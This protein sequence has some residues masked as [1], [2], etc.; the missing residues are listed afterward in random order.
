MPPLL[1]PLHQGGSRGAGHFCT[2]Q[3]WMLLP[4]LQNGGAS[5]LCVLWLPVS[6]E[7]G[8]SSLVRSQ[9][10]SPCSELAFQLWPG[11]ILR[12]KHPEGYILPWGQPRREL[13]NQAPSHAPG[14][15]SPPVLWDGVMSRLRTL[16]LHAFVAPV[17][18]VLPSL[19][20]GPQHSCSAPTLVFCWRPGEH[21][22]PS[23]HSQQ[24]I[25]GN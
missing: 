12:A 1:P 16:Q 5:R 15:V 10:Q 14:M 4:L 22:I 3:R 9:R 8:L 6:A 20:A 24:L 18:R 21:P 11:T 7:R 23:Y 25:L 2:F 13:G 19:V 17:E